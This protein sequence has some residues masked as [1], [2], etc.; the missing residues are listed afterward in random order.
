MSKFRNSVVVSYARAECPLKNDHTRQPKVD[1]ETTTLPQNI[2]HLSP[3]DAAPYP[4]QE[5]STA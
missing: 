5:I 1:D 2:R 4:R 3:W